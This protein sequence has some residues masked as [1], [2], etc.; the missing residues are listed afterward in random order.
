M[1]MRQRYVHKLQDVYDPDRPKG[2]LDVRVSFDFPQ[3]DGV[4]VE[5]PNPE[6]WGVIIENQSGEIAIMIWRQDF[7]QG[8][9]PELKIIIANPDVNDPNHDQP[10]MH[11]IRL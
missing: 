7:Q 4:I 6:G 9:D 8:V 1:S 3:D 11:E 10:R 5:S 2:T